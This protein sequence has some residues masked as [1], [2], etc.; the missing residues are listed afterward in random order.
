MNKRLRILAPT[1]FLLIAAAMIAACASSDPYEPPPVSDRRPAGEGRG[2]FRG[3]AGAEG[4]QGGLEGL[5]P[6]SWWRDAQISGAVNLSSDQVA[7]LEKIESGQGD[8]ITRLVRD[9]Q[10]AVRQLRDA[11][12]AD[13]AMSDDIVAAG[14]R[15]RSMRD[16]IL[17]RQVRMLAAER[18]VLAHQQ[19][20]ALQNAL[21]SRR[22]ERMQDRR[23][24][25][26]R[27]RGGWGGGM[28]GRRP[29]GFG[30]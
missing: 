5:P 24:A 26:P 1:I 22:S 17:D 23:G 29:G 6:G 10:V 11:L 18:L 14:Q 13:P 3:T 12:D 8:E 16:D 19:W 21:Q 9:S 20:T 4:L 30:G 28:G 7:A 2:G 27:G 15:V 25:S